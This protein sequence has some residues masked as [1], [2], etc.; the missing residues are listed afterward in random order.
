MRNGNHLIREFLHNALIRGCFCLVAALG[1][2]FSGCGEKSVPDQSMKTSTQVDPSSGEDKLSS[3]QSKEEAGLSNTKQ[4]ETALTPEETPSSEKPAPTEKLS[5]ATLIDQKNRIW[6]ENV[7]YEVWFDNPIEMLGDPELIT[8]KAPQIKNNSAVVTSTA[9]AHQDEKPNVPETSRQEDDPLWNSLVTQEM[10]Q[11]E[12]NHIRNQLNASFLSVAQYNK[13][14]ETIETDCNLLIS[15]CFLVDVKNMD[16]S[17]KESCWKLI[18]LTKELSE[19]ASS[20]GRENF[21]KGQ[22][23][24]NELSTILT[25]NLS[26]DPETNAKKSGLS[27]IAERPALMKKMDELSQSL[28]SEINSEVKF[29][30]SQKTVVHD[31]TLLA[32]LAWAIL[33]PGFDSSEDD[34]YREVAENMM[35]EALK[36]GQS[37]LDKNYSFWNENKNFVRKR[38][39]Q[40]H[41]DYRL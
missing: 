14:L 35:K 32:I 16:V 19:I 18:G 28:E 25:G 3:Q 26:G 41:A 37:S 34:S 17:W 23:L 2:T 13:S 30:S 10:V 39:D 15:L 29:E 24:F 22:D 8:F 33:Q 38:C 11:D 1:C 6:I 36:M 5:Q 7:P 20:K 40:C 27:D 9:P 4:E 12:I 31:S 21:K